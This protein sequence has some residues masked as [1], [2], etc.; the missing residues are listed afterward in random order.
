MSLH[1]VSMIYLRHDFV[2]LH[3]RVSCDPRVSAGRQGDTLSGG[4][5]F[6]L[7][8]MCACA[9]DCARASGVVSIASRSLDSGTREARSLVVGRRVS[10]GPGGSRTAAH[11]GLIALM[12][13][14]LGHHGD[15]S[16]PLGD[17]WFFTHSVH[18]IRFKRSQLSYHSSKSCSRVRCS[19]V[20]Q[21]SHAPTSK[22]QVRSSRHGLTHDGH[23][24][25]ISPA[26]T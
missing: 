8:D 11:D 2:S 19:R 17:V 3:V 22:C 9:H 24:T 6:P 13:D 21:S 20:M 26:L 15:H 25:R 23:V 10:A 14:G 4:R 12:H 16:L 7:R 5:C 1:R 18:L